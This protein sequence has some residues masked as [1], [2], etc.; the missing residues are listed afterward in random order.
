M[1]EVLEVC[2]ATITNLTVDIIHSAILHDSIPY[3]P[4]NPVRSIHDGSC[5]VPTG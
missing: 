3:V 1:R 5:P 4:R 2:R